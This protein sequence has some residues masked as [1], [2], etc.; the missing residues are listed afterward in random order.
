[1]FVQYSAIFTACHHTL[2]QTTFTTL[3]IDRCES[4][5]PFWIYIYM[6][7]FFRL[8]FWCWMCEMH[9][10]F[11]FKVAI[12]L[13]FMELYDYRL[14][15]LFR[16]TTEVMLVTRSSIWIFGLFTR[17]LRH[18]STLF[19]NFVLSL[20]VLC[21]AFSRALG[22]I[23]TSCFVVVDLSLIFI[24]FDRHIVQFCTFLGIHWYHMCS[25]WWDNF[26]AI[27]LVFC[28]SLTHLGI[29]LRFISEYSN[30]R[31]QNVHPSKLKW[32]DNGIFDP[33]LSNSMLPSKMICP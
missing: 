31:S 2:V 12:I 5:V 4:P 3:N 32:A 25:H 30:T 6:L 21:Y 29:Y 26:T 28:V 14:C 11:L 9:C 1:M 8:V 16:T 13:Y 15:A 17:I 7:L 19:F 22:N 18:L 10:S 24:F 23:W 20:K 33:N 27:T